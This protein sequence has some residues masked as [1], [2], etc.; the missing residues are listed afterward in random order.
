M[1]FLVC[2]VVLIPGV[3]IVGY[4]TEAILSNLSQYQDWLKPFIYMWVEFLATIIPPIPNP[5]TAV[6]GG[7]FFGTLWGAIYTLIPA[8][9][10][11]VFLFYVARSG[12][13][14][15]FGRISLNNVQV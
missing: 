6:I 5:I 3:F 4:N 13:D 14:T 7:Y 12:R 10:A 2:V 1:I 8:M 9:L 11:S 15:F